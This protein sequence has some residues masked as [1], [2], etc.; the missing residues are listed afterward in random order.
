MLMNCNMFIHFCLFL[1]NAYFLNDKANHVD[2][3][4]KNRDLCRQSQMECHIGKLTFNKLFN[5]PD[6]STKTKQSME[7]HRAIMSCKQ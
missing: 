5:K 6:S 2:D 4:D 1:Q 7:L 3:D